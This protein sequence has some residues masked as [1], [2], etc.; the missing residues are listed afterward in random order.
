MVVPPIH[1][2]DKSIPTFSGRN[3]ATDIITGISADL[4]KGSACPDC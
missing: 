1:K 2:D 4:S 3:C